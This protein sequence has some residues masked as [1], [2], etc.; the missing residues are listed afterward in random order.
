MTDQ[1]GSV[2][3]STTSRSLSS[4]PCASP[5]LDQIVS[6]SR[7]PCFDVNRTVGASSGLLPLHYAI[8]HAGSPENVDGLKFVL[9]FAGVD[10]N[11]KAV[12]D[13]AMHLLTPMHL[14]VILSFFLLFLKKKNGSW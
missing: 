13:G 12:Y 5:V 9:A 1:M 8:E 11:A 10:V 6:W 7:N 14:A 3:T 4:L 2:T